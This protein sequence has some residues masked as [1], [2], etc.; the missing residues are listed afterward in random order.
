MP[1]QQRA[2]SMACLLQF[3]NAG[4][5][6]DP[7]ASGLARQRRHLAEVTASALSEGG[8]PDSTIYAS[9][10]NDSLLSLTDEGC[11]REALG[12][13]R[14]RWSGFAD[15]ACQGQAK[16]GREYAAFCAARGISRVVQVV[17]RSPDSMV[18]LVDLRADHSAQSARLNDRLAYGRKRFAPAFTCDIVAAEILSVAPGGDIL[19]LHFHLAVRASPDGLRAM[20]A[21]FKRSGWSWW[22][23]VTAPSPERHDEPGSLA[24]YVAKGLAHALLR[25][26]DGGRALSPGNTVELFRQTHGLALTR[27]T[28]AFR[29]WKA[30]L[31]RDGLVVA[32][33]RHGRFA[34]RPRRRTAS[35]PRFRNRMLAG[36]TPQ[37]LRLCVHDFGDGVRR[38]AMLIRGDSAVTFADVAA[39]YDLS[40][41]VASA[42]HALTDTLRNTSIPETDPCQRQWSME[43]QPTVPPRMPPNRQRQPLVP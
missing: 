20:A 6:R 8:M 30:E 39:S 15:Q 9:T 23:A 32:E 31:E 38:P 12:Q 41:A 10:L 13:Q 19:D 4:Q 22:D 28:G 21:Y 1:S 24:H 5:R 16:W 40:I 27:S 43:D 11:L 25:P 42:R 3:P 33:D 14:R 2:T 26:G 18:K 34:L 17:I 29:T 7:A 35:A 37:L 36:T